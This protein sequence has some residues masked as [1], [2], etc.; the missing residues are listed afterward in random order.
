[1]PSRQAQEALV[2]WEAQVFLVA[3]F[4]IQLR[5]IN[6]DIIQCYSPTN[7]REVEKDD[8]YNRLSTII[9]SRPKRNI[10]MTMGDLNTKV[11]SN[12]RGYEEIMGQQKLREMSENGKRL[13]DFFSSTSLVIGGSISQHK[14]V[15]K[16]T[17]VSLD[18][19]K[20]RSRCSFRPPHSGDQIEFKAK[21][22]NWTGNTTSPQRNTTNSILKDTK[23]LQEL[24]I[25]LTNSFQALQK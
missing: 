24:K 16:A 8:F 18:H 23:K 6:K 20:E 14:R 7:D 3:S 5:R 2:R 11:R 15:Y 13:A 19:K 4:K 22:K 9:Q 21:K 25:T 1:M 12:N 17:W 10:I